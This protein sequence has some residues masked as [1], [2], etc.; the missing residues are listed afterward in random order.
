[1]TTADLIK[2]CQAA[3]PGKR[4]FAAIPNRINHRIWASTDGNLSRNVAEH[5]A[6]ADAA[7][8]A[9]TDPAVVE[10]LVR[11]AVALADDAQT[12]T[13][14]AAAD[15]KRDVLAALAAAGVEVG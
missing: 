6:A 4:R 7:L 11:C 12:S 9:A 10:A 3:T 13:T 5:V 14:P 8:I 2:L 1:M 15:R